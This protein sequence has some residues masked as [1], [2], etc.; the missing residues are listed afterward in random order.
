MA[1][2]KSMLKLSF[3][4]QLP[5]CS[6]YVRPVWQL[7]L[8]ILEMDS[9]MDFVEQR[10]GKKLDISWWSHIPTLPSSVLA[11]HSGHH[12]YHQENTLQQVPGN[13]EKNKSKNTIQLSQSHTNKFT[14]NKQAH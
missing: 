2:F 8:A 12:Q 5:Y 7:Q 4:Q 11:P 13:E 1:V 10:V 6:H 9:H 14:R 3:D